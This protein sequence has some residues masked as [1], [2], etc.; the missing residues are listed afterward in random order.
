MVGL[1]GK[2]LKFVKPK[3]KKARGFPMSLLSAGLIAMIVAIFSLKLHAA[4]RKAAKLQHKVNV[5][6]EKK[7]A[8]IVERQV[9]DLMQAAEVA[10]VKIQDAQETKK[11]LQAK[12]KE[13]RAQAKVVEAQLKKATSWSNL[14]VK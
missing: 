3:D 14:L 5:Q 13:T 10:A 4:K 9:G 11:E 2:L 1:L 12:L 6:E 7:K 8:A